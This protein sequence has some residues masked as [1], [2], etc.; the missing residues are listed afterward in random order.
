[1]DKFKKTP[2]GYHFTIHPGSRTLFVV[3]DTGLLSKD[4]NADEKALFSEF[5]WRFVSQLAPERICKHISVADVIPASPEKAPEKLDNSLE[6]LNQESPGDGQRY[7]KKHKP[8]L[9][10]TLGFLLGGVCGFLL[11][12]LCF[13]LLI[14]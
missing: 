14:L 5:W 6:M 1:M 10:S 7:G 3:I 8:G 11:A 13:V 12:A 9:K 4:E 2:D